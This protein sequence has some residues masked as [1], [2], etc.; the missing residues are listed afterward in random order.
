[1]PRT[2]PSGLTRA[3]AGALLRQASPETQCPIALRGHGHPDRVHRIGR[4]QD[5]IGRHGQRVV[6]HRDGDRG[7]EAAGA[8]GHELRL[9]RLERGDPARGVHR[10]HVGGERAPGHVHLPEPRVVGGAEGHGDARRLEPEERQ[11]LRRRDEARA[12]RK[13]GDRLGFRR[14]ARDGDGHR[15]LAGAGTN[16]DACA[17]G[18]HS[19]DG[20]VGFHLRHGILGHG[21]RE[22]GLGEEVAIR[23]IGAEEES[24]ALAHVEAKLRGGDLHFH[25]RLRPER[26]RGQTEERSEAGT[27]GAAGSGSPGEGKG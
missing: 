16:F 23:V 20:A 10:G 1:M 15:R 4:E 24:L 19:D 3:T 9:A 13:H 12:G 27:G 21:E 5:T 18:A 2:I 11:R 8:G 17:A 6:G 14:R 26:G 25:R 7:G 22:C